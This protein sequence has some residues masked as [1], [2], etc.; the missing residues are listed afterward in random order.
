MS[1]S[2]TELLFIEKRERLT[3]QWP[4]F[5]FCLLF[6][7]AGIVFWLWNETPHMV[8]PW[9]VATSLEEGTLAES[10]LTAMAA[11]LP[12]VVLVLIAAAGAFVMLLSV[13]CANERRLIQLLG[14]E[15][16]NPVNSEPP[17]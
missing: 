11:M 7:F 5:G 10:T 17:S 16:V 8:D 4:I 1:L 15:C 2:P 9:L 12:L 6:L 13:A 14:R 3:R